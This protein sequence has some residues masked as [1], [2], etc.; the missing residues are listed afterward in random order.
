MKHCTT[1]GTNF[2]DDDLRYCTDD[3]TVLLAGENPFA[4]EAQATKIFPASP[5]TKVMSP[6]RPTEYEVRTPADQ[7]P[8]AP[9]YGWA[10]EAPAAW[11]PPAPPAYP[12]AGQQQQQTT[13][14]LVSLIFG[15][16]AFTIGWLCLGIPLGLVAV[17]LGLVALSQI[18]RDPA[19][20]GGKPLAIGGIVTGGIVMLVKL[21]LLVIWIVALTF[22]SLSR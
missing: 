18:R 2:V 14:A 12:S 3:G 21:A 22:G 1:C 8:A 11:T 13:A 19:K 6:P 9:L 10:N 16:V 15:I 7:P 20:Y 17:V 5:P 4:Q